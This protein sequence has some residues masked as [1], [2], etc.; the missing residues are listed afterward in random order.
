MPQG[1]EQKQKGVERAIAS[2]ALRSQPNNTTQTKQINKEAFVSSIQKASILFLTKTTTKRRE[3]E[4]HAKEETTP[5]EINST[6]QRAHAQGS[7][8]KCLAFSLFNCSRLF[9]LVFVISTS[10]LFCFSATVVGLVWPFWLFLIQS[11]LTPTSPL[12]LS[13]S[14]TYC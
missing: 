7:N 12:T 14:L 6:V 4:V 1:R 13:L 8:F 2:A 3:E 9:L 11:W 10:C 5:P